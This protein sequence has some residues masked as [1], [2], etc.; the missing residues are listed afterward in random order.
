M[1]TVDLNGLWDF[2]IDLDPKYHNNL[3]HH[4]GPCYAQPDADR[5]NW[6]QVTVPGVWNSYA[7][8]LD[9]YEGVCWL[10][11]EFVVAHLPKNAGAFL[12]F[13]GVNYKCR[14]FLNGTLVGEHEGGYTEFHLDV[15]AVLK[16]GKNHLAVE[17][18][19]RAAIT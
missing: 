9:I 2:V 14:V 6:D 19:N 11:R 18:D 4:N 7:E 17:V 8:R 10:A 3:V 5:R 16:E 13:G 15:A 1:T 12:R